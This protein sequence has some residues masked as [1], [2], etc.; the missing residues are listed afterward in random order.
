MTC[1]GFSRF[2]S[3][4]AVGRIAQ[5]AIQAAVTSFNDVAELVVREEKDTRVDSGVG[6]KPSFSR[7]LMVLWYSFMK[8]VPRTTA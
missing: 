5:N 8:A 6:L 2:G 4:S 1:L 3:L 7:K